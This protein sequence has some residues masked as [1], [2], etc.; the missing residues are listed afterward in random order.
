MMEKTFYRSQGKCLSFTIIDKSEAGVI[1]FAIKEGVNESI[2]SGIIPQGSKV[3]EIKDALLDFINGF[4]QDWN[5]QSS[6][7]LRITESE[8][9]SDEDMWNERLD[10][11]LDMLR[12]VQK[13]HQSYCGIKDSNAE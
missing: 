10:K 11:E 13:E 3:S 12:R 4:N 7:W 8:K 5:F 2:I 1:Y 9:S 6:K